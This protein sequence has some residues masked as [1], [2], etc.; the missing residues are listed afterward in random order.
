MSGSDTRGERGRGREDVV[1]RMDV[2]KRPDGWAAMANGRKVARAGTKREAVRAAA[3]KAR[4][5]DAAWA[6]K[7]HRIDGRVQEERIYPSSDGHRPRKGG[8]PY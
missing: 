5:D 6:V 2:V 4:E 3:A 8:F 1:K 7:I